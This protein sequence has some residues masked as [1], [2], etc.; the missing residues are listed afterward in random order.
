MFD[1]KNWGLLNQQWREC[2]EIIVKMKDWCDRRKIKLVIVIL[3]DQFQVDQ[4]LRQAVF[5]KYERIVK[6]KFRP[7][8]PG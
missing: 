5:T 4:A 7:E 2:S 1:K 6:R 3:P 8:L